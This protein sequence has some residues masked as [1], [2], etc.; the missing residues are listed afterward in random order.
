MR[1]Q[2]NSILLCLVFTVCLASRGNAGIWQDDFNGDTL[3][4]GWEY[5]DPD[6]A[7]ESEVTDGSFVIDL[8]GNHDM[9][10][11]KIMPLSSSG[12]R[13]RATSLLNPTL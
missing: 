12:R 1:R 10:G 8:K 11:G 9:W 3:G 5:I 4:E 2:W 7:N 6:A 13:R